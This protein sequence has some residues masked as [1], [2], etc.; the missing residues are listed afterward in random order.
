MGSRW[1]VLMTVLWTPGATG[2]ILKKPPSGIGIGAAVVVVVA[3]VVR[4]VVGRRVVVVVGGAGVV[5]VPTWRYIHVHFSKSQTTA[6]TP[7]LPTP[8]L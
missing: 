1:P 6:Q 3:R 5:V 2:A 7:A 4:R 8:Q